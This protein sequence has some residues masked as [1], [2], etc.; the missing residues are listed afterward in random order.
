M[1]TVTDIKSVMQDVFNECYELR[2][3]GQK[4]YAGGSNGLGNFE[5]LALELSMSREK[6]LWVYLKKHL[7]GIVSYMNGHKSQRE[8][9]RGRIN[10][11]IVYLVLLRAMVEDNDKIEA[12]ITIDAGYENDDE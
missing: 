6:I 4:E 5:R 9:V 7:D 1:M 10:D 12:Q 3:A 11:A 8:N 2:E